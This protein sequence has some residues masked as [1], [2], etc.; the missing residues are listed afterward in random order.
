MKQKT[1]TAMAVLMLG[2]STYAH[3]DET[4]Y[5]KAGYMMLT[6]SGQFSAT[7]NNV[8]SKIDLEQDLNFDNSK[9]FT[10]EIGINLGNSLFTV[11]FVP[12]SFT[13]AGTLA[14]PIS[15][16]GQTFTAGTA[17]TSEFKA[18]IIDIGYTYYLINMDD[19]PSRFQLGIET[20]AKTIITKTSMTGA[21]IGS[22][23]NITVPIP[24]LGLRSRIALADFVGM[25]GRVGYLGYAGN[26]FLDTDIQVEFS[27]LPTMGIYAGYR[28]LQL[29][30]DSSGVFANV[31]FNGPYAGAF[32][33][34]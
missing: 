26:T 25:V 8:G 15:Y 21:G 32:F 11:G 5:I 10:G 7:I 2:I 28:H 6:P 33:R 20:S 24:T 22:T 16:N 29:E 34:F 12:V 31:T 19:L 3:A 30:V 1:L 23:K 14:R 13:G 4:I 27:P 18:D 17:V 9:Q